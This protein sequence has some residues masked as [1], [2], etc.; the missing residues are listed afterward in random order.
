[1]TT[2]NESKIYLQNRKGFIKL[3]LT[4]GAHLVPMVNFFQF[5]SFFIFIK[6]KY[7]IIKLI[8]M[9]L[10]KMKLIKSQNYLWVRV[11]KIIII[12]IIKLIIIFIY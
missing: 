3:A 9:H 10:E 6:I 2:P 12:Q 7:N 4:H 11:L 8:S 5:F 1:M